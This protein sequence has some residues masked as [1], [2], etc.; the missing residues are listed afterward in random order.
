MSLFRPAGF[1]CPECTTEI[2]FDVADS[3][4][5]DRRPDLREAILDGSYQRGTCHAC[6]CAFR[7]PPWFVY[8]DVGRGQWILGQPAGLRASWAEAEASTQALF[9][10][11][12]GSAASGAARRIGGRLTPRLTFGWSGLREKLV[13]VAA[14]LDDAALEA[15]KAL[16]LRSGAAPAPAPDRE[17]RLLA[18]TPERLDLGWGGEEEIA[19]VLQIPRSLY[20]HVSAEPDWQE[21]R[22]RL[23]AGCFVDLDRLL[24]D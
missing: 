12:F 20:E 7:A 19:T 10:R 14:G 4:N 11:L 5:A 16:L 13:A 6:G 3:L 17:L 18:A 8:L 1:P 15:L 2:T 22:T 21:T 24:L 9:D 23:A